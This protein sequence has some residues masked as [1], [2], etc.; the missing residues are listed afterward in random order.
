MGRPVVYPKPRYKAPVIMKPDHF[1]W[2]ADADWPGVERRVLGPFTERATRIEFVKIAPS[3]AIE[4]GVK[5]AQHVIFVRRGTGGCAD[6]GVDEGTAVLLAPGE[7]ARINAET[8]IELLVVAL[9]L[10][11]PHTT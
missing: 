2:Q 6:V 8:E 3:S 5:D 11:G 9:P 1:A 10:I 7:T 4:L